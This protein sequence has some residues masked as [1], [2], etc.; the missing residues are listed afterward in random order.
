MSYQF[1]SIGFFSAN[2][3]LRSFFV[4]YTI[5]GANANTSRCWLE[6]FLKIF[7][8]PDPLKRS[9]LLLLVSYNVWF[10]LAILTLNLSLYVVINY[11]LWLF[12]RLR[13]MCFSSIWA[14]LYHLLRF[15]EFILSAWSLNFN[16]LI[17]LRVKE[18]KF[19]FF[20]ASSTLSL[21]LLIF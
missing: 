11:F 16:D 19:L 1:S 17:S 2:N 8:P 21:I 4:H 6:T 9:P 20:S 18:V 7:P 10:S 12:I 15:I 13:A 5:S 3:F 14:F